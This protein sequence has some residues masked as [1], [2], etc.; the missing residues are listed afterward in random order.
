MWQ[1]LRQRGRGRHDERAHAEREAARAHDG[2]PHARAENI[3]PEDTNGRGIR[4]LHD[5]APLCHMWLYLFAPRIINS[6]PPP[7][8]GAVCVSHDRSL[9]GRR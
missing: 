3:R 9:E 7:R 4:L 6:L 8:P 1:R 5:G 2:P